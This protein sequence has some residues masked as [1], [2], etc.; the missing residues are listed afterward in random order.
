MAGVIIALLGGVGLAQEPRPDLAEF[1]RGQRELR[2]R[3]STS[4]ERVITTENAHR[5]GTPLFIGRVG[6]ALPAESS[7]AANAGEGAGIASGSASPSG[8]A[9]ARDAEEER[10]AV[11]EAQRRLVQQ[12]QDQDVRL[13]L[14]INRLRSEYLAPVVSQ[15]DREASMEG[16]TRAQADLET[17]EA[18]LAEEQEKLQA[19]EQAAEGAEAP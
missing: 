5:T 1:A 19:L 18:R 10:A 12:L 13:R 14:E 6:E 16:M 11:L 17:L 3:Q 9:A 2:D 8:D 7:P 4:P 15:R